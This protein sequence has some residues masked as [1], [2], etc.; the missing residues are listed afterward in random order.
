MKSFAIVLLVSGALVAA[1]G[2][3]SKPANTTPENKTGTSAPM[4]GSTGG[5]GYGGTATPNPCGGGI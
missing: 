5:A 2:S 1:C 3:K 4:K